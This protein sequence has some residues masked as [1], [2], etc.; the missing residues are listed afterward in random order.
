MVPQL[1][2]DIYR[3]QT[4]RHIPTVAVAKQ[5][6]QLG[7]FGGYIPAGKFQPI[8]G[9]ENYFFVRKVNIAGRIGHIANRAV[10]KF[11]LHKIQRPGEYAIRDEDD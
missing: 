1:V 7:T 5:N 4:M 11:M 9:T 3:I 2:Q 10:E 6:R 8:L